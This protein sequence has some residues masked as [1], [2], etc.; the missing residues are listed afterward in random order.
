MT[1]EPKVKLIVNDYS[2]ALS[3]LFKINRVTGCNET[4]DQKKPHSES[5]NTLTPRLPLLATS[6][7]ATIRIMTSLFYYLLFLVMFK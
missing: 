1:L 4:L 2:N 5:Q 6:Q 3:T 7:H